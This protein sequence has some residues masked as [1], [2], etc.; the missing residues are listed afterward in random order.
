MMLPLWLPVFLHSDTGVNP[1][2]S[3][4]ELFFD[5]QYVPIVY[6][7]GRFLEG[8]NAGT[9][10][11][12]ALV[13]SLYVCFYTIRMHSNMIFGR[14]SNDDVFGKVV[15]YIIQVCLLV[16]AVHLDVG[17]TNL[18]QKTFFSSLA[19]AKA[20][21]LVYYL[22]CLY[23]IPHAKG[24]LVVVMIGLLVGLNC[25]IVCV[26]VQDSALLILSYTIGNVI[27]N[28][29]LI[30]GEVVPSLHVPLCLDH[31]AE[32]T[33]LL[34]ILALGEAVLGMALGS[35]YYSLGQGVLL[36]LGF[37]L[38]FSLSLIYF[39]SQPL[40][41]SKHAVHRGKWRCVSYMYLFLF[42]TFGIFVVGVGV[43]SIVKDS[44]TSDVAQTFG[45]R[46]LS[47]SCGGSCLLLIVC[48]T[49]H[50]DWDRDRWV[51]V[52]SV[53]LHALRVLI[54]C[55]MFIIDE[56]THEVSVL[57]G[58]LTGLA[59]IKNVLDGLTYFV[60]TKQSQLSVQRFVF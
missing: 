38:V 58:V 13:F 29:T 25:S 46:S 14:F 54:C 27:E 22:K 32:R 44:V 17:L 6:Q 11:A 23:F 28:L 36:V 40:D 1:K 7:F 9:T 47:V 35:N 45:A 20:L 55:L 4:V 37:T 48:R 18:D 42:L 12:V 41:K 24:Y 53:T 30:L 52:R 26:F 10:E 51:S 50:R 2:V 33:G 15:F 59:V 31:F 60:T 8:S 5:L 39:D 16:M 43:T 49:L 56:L 19:V 57:L 3:W 34:V 21:T